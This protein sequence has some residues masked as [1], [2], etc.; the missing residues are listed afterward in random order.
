VR[1]PT[2]ALVGLVALFG[3]VTT[4]LPDREWVE[5]RTPHFEIVSS[6]SA[7][8]TIDLARDAELFHSATEFVLGTTFP[9]PAVPTRIYAFDGRG[10][11][12]P[13]DVRGEPGY[14]LPSLRAAT[15]VLRTGDGWR[16]DATE[17]LRHE[18]VHYLLRNHGGFERPLWFDEGAAEFLSTV[19]VKDGHVDLGRFRTD[20]VTLLRDQPWIPLIRILRTGDLEDWGRRKRRIFQAESWA[21]VHYLNFGR[22]ES[23]RGQAQLGRYFRRIADGVSHE[24]AVE[25]AFGV[26]S[27]DLDRELQH[28]V[29]SKRFASVVFRLQHSEP[30]EAPETRPLERD[31]VLT[32]L[33]WLSLSLA[34]AKQAQRYFERAVG[35]DP[36]NA[37]AHAGLGAADALRGR[38]EAAIPHY[39]R[40]VGIAPD[41]ALNQVDVGAYYGGRARAT[42]DAE[43]RASFA[44]LARHHYA[45]SWE[46]GDP[47]PEAYAMYGATFLLEGEAMERAME[48][49]EAANRMLGSSLEIKLLL[50]RLYSKLGRHRQAR[51][52]VVAVFS[53]THSAAMRD[54]ARD[55]LARIDESLALRPRSRSRSSPGE[56]PAR[57]R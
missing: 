54:T 40:A 9:A 42:G 37:R 29:R 32:H 12:R 28:F 2:A 10:L 45:R 43:A 8:D 3:C 18:Y 24:R 11:V 50:A 38:W 17:S 27:S 23:G 35:D 30:A 52:Q 20:H 47:L 19:E 57:R 55:L 7:N 4:P 51:A 26:S 53:R 46:L 56:T 33:G 48:P 6:L 25:Q 16:L 31:E 44:A 1:F 34:R 36:E 22:G 49:L 21:F 5:V 39:K 13:F 41:D 15:I 14:F